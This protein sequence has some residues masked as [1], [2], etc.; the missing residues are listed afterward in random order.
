MLADIQEQIFP[1]R[2]VKI[3]STIP[4]HDICYEISWFGFQMFGCAERFDDCCIQK[5]DAR[6]KRAAFALS[7]IHTQTRRKYLLTWQLSW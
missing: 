3:L 2:S 5:G 4:P 7:N 6:I 1:S